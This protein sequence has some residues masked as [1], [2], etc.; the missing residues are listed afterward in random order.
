MIE[1]SIKHVII[2]KYFYRIDEELCQYLE[3]KMKISA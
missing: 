3:K 1:L 2:R